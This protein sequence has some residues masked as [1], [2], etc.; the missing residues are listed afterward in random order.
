MRAL[1]T[2]ICGQDGSY[3]AEFL[4][5]KGYTVF[6]LMR[7]VDSY[8]NIK[9]IKDKLHIL[10][11][12]LTDEKSIHAAMKEAD[13]DEI[14]NLGAISH[15]GFSFN[16][17]TITADA[18]GLSVARVLKCIKAYNPKIKFYQASTSELF[19]EVE[20]PTQNEQ[21]PL[22]PES[23][24]AVAKLYGYWMTRLYRKAYG[25]FACN[26]IL[27]NH[28]SPR[29]GYNF[30]TRKVT[31]GA[32]KIAHGLQDH[33][34][35][36]NIDSKR[37]WGYAKD[38]IECMWL[39]LQQDKPDDYV[40]ATGEPHSVRELIEEVFK[41]LSMEL[42]WEG[43]GINE[44]GK[45]NGKVLV[46]ISEEFYRPSDVNTLC[47]DMSKAKKQLGWEPKTKF[48]ELVKI[49]LEHDLKQIQK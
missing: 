26:G 11:G 28:E 1:V 21:S 18:T 32:C 10:H 37:D 35:M 24:Y 16:E 47:G 42:T 41:Y 46:K 34:T 25:M 4:L 19:G 2:G 9:H 8:E 44:V 36:G 17:P 13:P 12:D 39:M 3:L 6:G 27:F 22:K 33:L 20:T 15:V 49:M 29:R 7:P 40:I 5:E 48:K 14:Y 38:Y 30:V 43:T 45:H 23:P 31:Y